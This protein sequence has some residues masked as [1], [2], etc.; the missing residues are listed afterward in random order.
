MKTK[1]ELRT[2]RD[3]KQ[4]EYDNVDSERAM[5]SSYLRT[6]QKEIQELDDEIEEEMEPRAITQQDDP[7]DD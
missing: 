7:H 1:E 6:L 4:R 3:E 5:L 2:L